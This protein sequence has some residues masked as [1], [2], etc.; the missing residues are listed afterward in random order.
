MSWS[1]GSPGG[2]PSTRTFAYLELKGR[3]IHGEIPPGARISERSLSQVLGVSR[4]PLREALLQLESE[5]LVERTD[6]GGWQV[7]RLSE[8]HVRDIFAVRGQLEVV[9]VRLSI[10]R[11]SDQEVVE[12]ESFLD[13]SE[14]AFAVNDVVS[15]T[16]ANGEFHTAVYRSAHSRWLETTIEPVRNQTIRIRFLIAG[17]VARPEY[18]EGHRQIFDAL[19]ARNPRTAEAIMSDHVEENL[20]VAIR[21]LDV[22]A[23]P[24]RSLRYPDDVPTVDFVTAPRSGL[25]D[26]SAAGTTS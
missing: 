22:L 5:N 2:P 13:A 23:G 15:M 12:L 14:T 8:R 17:G 21:H 24:G 10:E 26:M 1:G 16:G 7:P 25:P 3:M 4:T 9:A 6:S 19:R 18:S 20:H 11:A